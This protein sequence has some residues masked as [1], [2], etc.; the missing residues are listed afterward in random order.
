MDEQRGAPASAPARP[1][2]AR[3]TAIRAERELSWE[4]LERLVGVSRTTI[5]KWKRAARPPQ[6]AT[7][8]KVAERLGI[9]QTE[10]LTLAGIITREDAD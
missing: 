2:W 5:D 3:I 6:A 9:D 10:A 8:N 4:A 7:V 1:L